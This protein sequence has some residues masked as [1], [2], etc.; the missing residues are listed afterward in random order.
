MS[1][2]ERQADELRQLCHTGA[3]AR[4][5]DLAFEHFAAFGVNDDIVAR[6]TEAIERTGAADAVRRRFA[7]LRTRAR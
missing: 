6:L 1:H 5:V 2:R 3:L 7:E 4:A